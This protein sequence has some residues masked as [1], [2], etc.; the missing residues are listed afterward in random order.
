MSL[1]E[2]LKTKATEY[3]NDDAQLKGEVPP[4]LICDFVIEKYKQYR[5]FTEE[6][7]EEFVEN[8][9]KNHLSTLAMAV[10]DLFSKYGAEGEASHSEK[11]ITRVYENSY[12]SKSLFKDIKPLSRLM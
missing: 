9:I 7:T 5:H 8:D 4:T 6:D 11:N 3:L 2:E 10:V 12:I 1:S